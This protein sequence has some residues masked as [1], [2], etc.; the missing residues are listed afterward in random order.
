MSLIRRFFFITMPLIIA[1]TASALTISG[2]VQTADTHA[3]ID[4]AVVTFTISSGDV[5]T[6]RTDAKGGYRIVGIP[7]QVMFGSISASKTGFRPIKTF[8]S[9]PET[10]PTFDFIL[11]P[12]TG[13]G[14]KLTG[15]VTDQH[16]TS[17]IS[18]VQVDL[19]M[20]GTKTFMKPFVS[21][22][23]A[24]NGSFVFD[25]L[26]A[27]TN[28]Q[29]ATIASKGGY[30]SAFTAGITVTPGQIKTGNI[31]LNPV[32]GRLG[33]IK[34]KITT[35]ADQAAIAH[36]LIILNLNFTS[37]VKFVDSASTNES[38]DYTFDSIPAGANISGT[39]QV[40]AFANGFSSQGCSAFK[41]DS[42]STVTQN[43]ALGAVVL[44]NSSIC[45]TVTDSVS[46][47]AIAGAQVTLRIHINSAWLSLDSVMTAAN[48]SY[49]FKGLDTAEYS[50]VVKKTAFRTSTS[51]SFAI[52]KNSSTVTQ[53]IALVS[54]NSIIK[55]TV[56]DSA[57]SNAIAGAQVIL[58]MH[59][60]SVWISI[61]SA[62]AEANG[63]YIFN[64]LDVG[65]YGVAVTM[66]DYRSFTSPSI[67]IH[68]SHDT[69]V[70]TALL[71]A[72]PKGTLCVFVGDSRDSA[73]ISASVSAVEKLSGGQTGQT[74]SGIT[75]ANGWVTFSEI[76]AG[77]FDVTAATPG[78][79]TTTQNGR[80][81]H[82]KGRDT[83]KI[84]LVQATGAAKVIKGVI[85]SSAG[86][87]VTGGLV[88]LTAQRPGGSTLTLTGASDST[89]AYI[90]IGIPAGITAGNLRFSKNGF[91]TKDTN[92][93]SLTSDTTAVSVLMKPLST[94]ERGNSAAF[95][96]H[97]AKKVRFHVY[98]L[99]GRLLGI[100][101]DMDYSA[102]VNTLRKT[103]RTHQSVILTWSDNGRA[104]Q[105]KTLIQ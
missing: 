39:Y 1:H 54:P 80:T 104:M 83:V 75:G 2:N 4:S 44:P 3:A 51:P 103:F 68:T 42:G 41:I 23:S 22:V 10:N 70:V 19:L 24:A 87:V 12:L 38:G 92:G 77:T 28:I 99:D 20:T 105:M 26:L 40:W 43:M 100:F 31:V 65:E 30:Y 91:S 16:T 45:G 66:A 61:D 18:G 69:M 64:K 55:G 50:L 89:G 36:A 59:T 94:R 46:L 62:V 73:I 67:L 82:V 63:A 78:Y 72:V 15:T 102:A 8:V 96:A 17:P 93:I 88:T 25:S 7:S 57:S 95:T 53:N 85:T 5:F 27:N 9:N 21:T 49:S 37:A 58:R 13:G 90:V 29:Y 60:S 71:S 52:V 32:G 98:G 79:N 48:G 84:N 34:G 35:A 74:Y 56:I 81:V 33:T 76:Y 97:T 6:G 86:S 101:T 47:N 11:I 14:T